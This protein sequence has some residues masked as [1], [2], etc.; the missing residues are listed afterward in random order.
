MKKSWLYALLVIAVIGATACGGLACPSEADA[1]R[2]AIVADYPA[3]DGSTSAHPLQR[4]VACDLLEVPCDWSAMTEENVQ[5]TVIP[6]PAAQVS[7]AHAQAILDITHNGTHGSYM[8]LI[9][10]AAD[11]IL[12]A[13]APSEDELAAA[14]DLSVQLDARPVALDAFV[15]MV[16]VENPVDDLSLETI[17]QIYI[18]EITTWDQIGVTIPAGGDDQSIH[19]YQR[20]RNSGS[21]ELMEDLVMQDLA[22]TDAPELITSS[23][24]GPLNAIGG[25]PWTGDGDVLG[26]GYSVYFYANFMFPH[27]YVKLIAV[28]G[29]HPT[30]ENIAS[31]LYPLTTEVFVAVREGT[32]E[33]SSAVQFRDWLFTPDGQAVIADSGYVPID[34]Q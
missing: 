11:V 5:R 10:G 32:P 31:W 12:V 2:A 28:E 27:E 20:N 1:L 8:N 16:N 13:R 30:S 33:D 34:L 4:W 6:D 9:E 15:F 25:N 18:G 14:E 7:E 29:V 26:I 22:M 17:Q 3:V 21:Q 19:A 23:M 24:V